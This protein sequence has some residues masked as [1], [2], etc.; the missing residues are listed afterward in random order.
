L[1]N[2]TR[3]EAGRVLDHLEC[4]WCAG[5][6]R[7]VALAGNGRKVEEYLRAAIFQRDPPIAAQTAQFDTA[8]IDTE[9]AGG[10]AEI[11]GE[12]LRY[13]PRDILDV[14]KHCHSL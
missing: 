12:L 14:P 13:F 1:L 5:A 10:A 6:N 9:Y 8:T 3:R 7:A 2:V 4:D 11:K